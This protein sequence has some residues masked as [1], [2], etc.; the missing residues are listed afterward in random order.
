MN[1]ARFI[2]G[3]LRFTAWLALG[4]IYVMPASAETMV[5][6]QESVRKRFPS[7][8]QISTGELAA[9]LSDSNRVQPLIVDVREANEFDVSHLSGALNLTSVL[10]LQLAM[11]SNSSTA[12]IYCSVG[13]RSSAVIEKLQRVGLTNVINLEGSIFKWANE[14]RPLYRGT[15]LVREVHGYSSKWRQLLNADV[16]VKL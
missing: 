5:S 16:P 3:G 2:S 8:R 14:G 7:V 15:N 1:L 13:Y 4:W 10:S 12:V 11:A 9:W 6:L